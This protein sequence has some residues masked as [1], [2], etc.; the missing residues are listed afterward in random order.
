RAL[1]AGTRADELLLEAGDQASAAQLDDLVVALAALE[2][3]AVDRALVV[4]DDE[5]ALLRGT[6]DR[7]ESREV[8]AQVLELVR[9]ALLVDLRLALADLE[10]GVVAERRG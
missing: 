3:H 5:V 10:A 1:V 2:R 8:L 7:L 6:L 4:D 9:D